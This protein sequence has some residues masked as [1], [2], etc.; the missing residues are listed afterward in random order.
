[1]AKVMVIGKI[2]R[3]GNSAA[4][5]LTKKVMSAAGVVAGQSV[6]IFAEEDRILISPAPKLDSYDLAQLIAGITNENCHGEMS[7][8]PPIGREISD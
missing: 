3:L 2:V 4:V 5:R 1:M 6:E 8:G 7:F